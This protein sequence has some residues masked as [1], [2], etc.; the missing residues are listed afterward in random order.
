MIKKNIFRIIIAC[1]VLYLGVMG[2]IYLNQR[3]LLYH[4]EQEMIGLESYNMPGTEEIFLTTKDGVKIQAWYKKPDTGKEMVIFYHGNSGHIPQRIDKLKE[5]NAMG[6]GFIIPAWRGFGKSEGFPTEKGILN[7][8]EA[9]IE[10]IK[11]EG[12]D[13]KK[14][15]VIGESLGTGVATQMAAKHEFKGLLLITPYTTIQDRA[16]EIYFYIPVK[17]LLKDNFDTINNISKV[18]VPVI[19]IHG[20]NDEIIPHTHSLKIIEKVNEPK[21]L[22]I[23]PGIN[24]TNYDSKTVF[25]E[26]RNFFKS[27]EKDTEVEVD[28]E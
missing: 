17:Y 24:H 6:Y 14:V 11:K 12:Y 27:L 16:S 3:T 2:Y 5:L 25:T 26:M 9:T 1:M 10:F 15:I 21:K 20:D 22:I 23:Y 13:L 28:Q 19:I 8:A 18:K 4:P 7:D